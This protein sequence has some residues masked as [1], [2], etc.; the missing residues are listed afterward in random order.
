MTDKNQTAQEQAHKTIDVGHLPP[1]FDMMEGN[2]VQA[3]AHP[4]LEIAEV[5]TKP[6]AWRD[7]YRDSDGVNI[8]GER[9]AKNATRSPSPSIQF[10]AYVY[11]LVKRNGALNLAYTDSRTPNSHDCDN[12]FL[13]RL[14]EIADYHPLIQFKKF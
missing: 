10:T 5:T 13:T 4:I 12:L 6:N 11:G 7:V 1:I 9:I 3:C 2:R 14:E 8:R